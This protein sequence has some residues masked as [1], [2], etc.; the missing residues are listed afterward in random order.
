MK[1]NISIRLRLDKM[2]YA[3]VVKAAI[4]T[5]ITMAALSGHL[6]VPEVERIV[7][8]LFG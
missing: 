6:T 1:L 4:A 5:A 2:T 7:R 8:L 3:A